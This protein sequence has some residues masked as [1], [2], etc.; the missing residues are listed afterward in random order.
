MCACV[1]VSFFIKE[2]F[3]M[4]SSFATHLRAICRAVLTCRPSLVLSVGW[5]WEGLGLHSP[6]LLCQSC[7]KFQ[8]KRWRLCTL[9]PYK[10]QTLLGGTINHAQ[11]CEFITFPPFYPSQ[12]EG[13][14]RMRHAY[15][16]VGTMTGALKLDPCG[17]Y[18]QRLP[19]RPMKV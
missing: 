4:A 3:K 8:P 16:L 13:W 1:C 17:W 9:D 18:P 14:G 19:V 11:L 5:D 6:T 7:L 2:A 12:R 15:V 10:M